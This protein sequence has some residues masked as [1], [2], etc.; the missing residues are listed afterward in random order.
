MSVRCLAVAS[1]ASVLVRS[2]VPATI[3]EM[4]A[5]RDACMLHD[6]CCECRCVGDLTAVHV[7][8]RHGQGQSKRQGE[9][10]LT[11]KCTR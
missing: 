1:A 6:F 4:T 3:G 7:E 8:V 10:T 2:Q 5:G 9:C 11:A